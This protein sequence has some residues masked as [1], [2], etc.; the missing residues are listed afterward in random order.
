MQVLIVKGKYFAFSSE[1]ICRIQEKAVPLH[2]EFPPRFPQNS[3]PGR[4]FF[5]SY[6]IYKE[7]DFGSESDCSAQ[8]QRIGD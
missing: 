4:N 5:F 2:R 3:V 6:E 1:K 8:R 7:T